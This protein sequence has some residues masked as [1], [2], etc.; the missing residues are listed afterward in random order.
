VACWTSSAERDATTAPDDYPMSGAGLTAQHAEAVGHGGI[1]ATTVF[2]S[3][4]VREGMCSAWDHRRGPMNIFL[5]AA[6]KRLG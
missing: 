2:K 3:V 4:A 5:D 1:A 6:Y